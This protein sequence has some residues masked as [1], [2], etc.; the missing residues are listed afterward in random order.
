MAY[1]PMQNDNPLINNAGRL[2]LH[3]PDTEKLRPIYADFAS[4]SFK[5]RIASGGGRKQPLA[6]AIGLKHNL[7]PLVFDAT[8]GLGRDGFIIASLGCQVIMCEQSSVIHALL[9]DGLR[10]AI[11]DHELTAIAQ[12]ISL[13]YGASQEVLPKICQAHR[14]DVIYLD[15]MFPHRRKSALVK[16]EMRALRSVVGD[17]INSKDL[18]KMALKESRQ[19]VVCKRPAQAP[20]LPGPLP[21]FSITTKKHRFDVYITTC[22]KD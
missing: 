22:D 10:R 4:P 19:R 13:H 18:L 9:E 15:P 1:P 2:E 6:R 14:P 3:L 8:A 11:H 16:K 12:R 21:N 17:D 20:S 5:Y 7:M